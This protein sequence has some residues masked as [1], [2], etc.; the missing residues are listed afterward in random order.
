MAANPGRVYLLDTNV[1]LHLVRGKKLGEYLTAT[2]ELTDLVYRP[3][4]S[5]V[6]HGEIRVIADRN[7]WGPEKCKALESALDNLITIDLNDQSIIEAYVEVSR[8]S[9]R[10]PRWR[11]CAFR[12]R[13]VDRRHSESRRDDSC[14]NGSRFPPPAPRLLHRPTC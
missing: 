7:G 9:Y 5:I 10:A 2:F 1:I 8:R 6:T 13:Q 14:Y 11:S 4:V 3:L 12:Q